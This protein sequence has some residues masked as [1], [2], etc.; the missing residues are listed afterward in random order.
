MFTERRLLV[1]G[2]ASAVAVAW[3]LIALGTPNGFSD[4]LI[5]LG[6]AVLL[7]VAVAWLFFTFAGDLFTWSRAFRS[8]TLGAA[9]LTPVL[10]YF[11]SRS[12]DQS[13]LSKFQFMI[14]VGWAASLGGVLWSLGGAT[15]DALREWR[16]ARRMSRIR[17]LYAP[18]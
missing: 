4:L 3:L 5:F 8:L 14:A 9:V 16:G 17:K 18:A 10:A 7:A 11:F 13:L 12:E 2:M 15:K 1:G 6:P